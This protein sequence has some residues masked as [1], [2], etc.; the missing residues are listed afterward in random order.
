MM[1]RI[2]MLAID[3]DV[4]NML[5]GIN[6]VA[7][8]LMQPLVEANPDEF[9]ERIPLARNEN[10][11]EVTIPQFTDDLFK[12]HFRMSRRSFELL[13]NVVGHNMQNRNRI[14]LV[15]SDTTVH[16]TTANVTQSEVIGEWVEMENLETVTENVPM[17]AAIVIEG[18]EVLQTQNQ[19][20]DSWSPSL[21][22]QPKHPVL[23]AGSS[24]MTEKPD[25]NCI[26]TVITPSNYF[27]I[28]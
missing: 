11:Y 22:R 14:D 10:F 18:A 9:R 16:N 28:L 1:D 4:P 13:R 5:N 6:H 21:L 7:E 27:N 25:D 23:Q 8:G 19:K 24:T 17:D 15:D 12:E 20:W 26:P 2:L 3:D